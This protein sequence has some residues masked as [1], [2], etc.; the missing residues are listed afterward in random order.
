MISRDSINLVLETARI[1]EVVG[2]VVSLKKRGVNYI[3]LCPFHNEKTPSFNVNP[4]RNIFKCFG[5]SEGGNPVDFL[6][7]TENMSFPEAVRSL[8]K[9]YNIQLE[10]TSPDPEQLQQQDERDSMYAVNDFAQKTF[11]D[12]LNNS[13]EGKSIGLSYFKERNFTADTINKFL[14]GYAMNAWSPLC[15]HAVKSGYDE[16]YIEKTGL[17]FRNE[18]GRMTDRFR[19]R[20]MFP[21]HNVSGRIIGFGGRILKKDD[22]TAKYINSPESEIYH[23]SRALYGIFQAKKSI[24]KNDEC[25]IVEGYTDVISL[26]QTGIENVVAPCGTALTEEQIRL[27]GRYTKNLTLLFDGDDAGIKAA[28][29]SI[30]LILLEGFNVR[31][32]L[33]PNKEDPDSFARKYGEKETLDFIRRSAVDFVEFKSKLVLESA[34][35]DP[36]RK[37]SLIHEVVD[38]IALVTDPILR[39]TYVKRCSRLLDIDEPVVLNEL[40][41]IRR[42]QLRKENASDEITELVTEFIRP[43]QTGPELTTEE[44]EKNIIRLLLN[45]GHI[46]L[47]IAETLTDEGGK[48]YEVVHEPSVARFIVEEISGDDIRFEHPIYDRILAEYAI[49]DHDIHFIEPSFFLNSELK[50]FREVAVEL[51]SPKYQLSE[52]WYAMHGISVLSEENALLKTVEQSVFHLKQ[53]KVM[54]MLEENRILIRDAHINGSDLTELLENHLRLERIKTEISKVLGIDILR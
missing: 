47:S 32:V 33:F 45:Y 48:P 5:C 36:I 16:S 23:K 49:I 42:Q 20:V 14:L 25:M 39:S 37:A 3:G 53:K 43:E 30:R 10:E 34:G 19:D 29:K 11:S 41:R 46:R 2:D 22:K 38:L 35:N 54:R 27:V 24:V 26:H 28:L 18:R 13:D 50:E 6:M 1:E 52:N 44:Q 8:A 4:A 15:D 12:W 17:G 40:N 7:K 21:I 9:R 51:L 31:I